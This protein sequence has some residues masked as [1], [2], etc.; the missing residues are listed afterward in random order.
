MMGAAAMSDNP[1]QKV[2]DFVRSA[3]QNMILKEMKPNDRIPT[4][5][6]LTEIFNVSR[7]SVREALQALEAIGIVEKRNGGTY[8]TDSMAECFVNPLSIMIKLNF[9]KLPDIIDIRML[10][11]TEAA[12]LAVL[13][14]GENE[15]SNLEKIVW[16]MQ[17]PGI[18]I[19]EYIKLD[20]RFHLAVAEASHNALLYQL[21]H[22]ANVVLS[23]HYP[24]VC[25][26]D[27]ARNSAIPLQMKFLEAIVRQDPAPAQDAMRRHLES[28]HSII[29]SDDSFSE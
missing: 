23:R 17:K 15:V 2:G 19:E 20:I 12:R 1:N 3:L 24:R 22:D 11:E 27:I 18:T 29:S 14:A 4:E 21:I 10:L 16:L 5:A 6:K 7:S 26:L 28:S 9:A 8:V 25:T 13:N